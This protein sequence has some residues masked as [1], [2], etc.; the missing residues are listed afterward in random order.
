MVPFFSGYHGHT[1]HK[2]CIFVQWIK[3]RNAEIKYAFLEHV[4][5]NCI[6]LQEQN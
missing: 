1:R 4:E 2:E 5:S 6:V 3:V